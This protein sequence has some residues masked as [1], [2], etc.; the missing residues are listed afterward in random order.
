MAGSTRATKS[1]S[2]NAFKQ[3][4]AWQA[5]E[6]D[7][8][9]HLKLRQ[10]NDRDLNQLL[11]MYHTPSKKTAETRATAQVAAGLLEYGGLVWDD[12]IHRWVKVWRPIAT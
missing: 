4:D 12:S 2:T 8:T 7:A 6:K 3:F 5:A 1:K 11:I 9:A 10:A